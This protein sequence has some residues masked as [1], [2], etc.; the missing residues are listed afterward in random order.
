MLWDLFYFIAYVFNKF[1]LDFKIW[2]QP[3][4]PSCRNPYTF[5]YR[6]KSW[7]KQILRPYLTPGFGYTY[8]QVNILIHDVFHDVC[9]GDELYVLSWCSTRWG[10]L[11]CSLRWRALCFLMILVKVMS[12]ML[13][14]CA[15]R[16]EDHCALL[17]AEIM[18]TFNLALLAWMA[19][20]FSLYS[21]QLNE[22]YFFLHGVHLRQALSKGCL[23]FEVWH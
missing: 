18:C 16:C 12:A 20:T 13:F 10:A 19:S 1:F 17:L 3:G 6:L 2:V 5:K 7:P 9:W 11:C 22:E 21:A 23:C 4:Y 15:H 8:T 14:H